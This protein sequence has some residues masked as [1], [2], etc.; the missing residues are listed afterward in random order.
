MITVSSDKVNAVH[1]ALL[2]LDRRVGEGGVAQ[3][4]RATTSDGRTV[5]VKLPRAEFADRPGSETL[6]RREFGFLVELSHENVVSVEG[7]VAMEGG[8]GLVMEY[9]SGGDAV[10]LAG[11][12]AERWLPVAV[13][14]ARAVAHVHAKGFVHRDIKP[15]N[16]LLRPGDRPC[17]IDF[18]MTANAGDPKPPG[19]GTVAYQRSSQRS[20][21][22]ARPGD[23]VHA[24]A[25]S[26]YELWTGRLPFGSEPEPGALGRPVLP[27]EL[28]AS[29]GPRRALAEAVSGTLNDD[30]EEQDRGLQPLL[31]ALELAVADD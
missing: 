24:L 28:P 26:V 14:V 29:T 1:D 18:A 19:G 31:D 9:V 10:S 12:P 3:V 25:A 22:P 6:L 20:G 5:A 11:A 2:K 4:W 30:A 23:D 15:R 16:V 13:G 8:L 7:L 17:L 27:S 21:R